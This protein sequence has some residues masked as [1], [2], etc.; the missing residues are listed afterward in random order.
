MR[1][2][3]PL[4]A[5][6]EAMPEPRWVMA[7]G[8]CAVSGGVAGGGYACGNGLDGVLPV[9]L[10]LPGCPPNPA[11][12]IEALLMFLDRRPQ[13]VSRRPPWRMN[14]G[15]SPLSAWFAG[16]V[17]AL[18][19]RVL[20]M[21]R[22]LLV[23]GGL[24]GRCRGRSALPGGAEAV[25]LPTRLAGEAVVPAAAGGAWLLGFGLARRPRLLAG[26]AGAPGER[27]VALRRRR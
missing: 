24:A 2:A 9:D 13:R 8:T 1:C 20:R 6:Y 4:R 16:G 22:L 12:M 17:L 15:R 5:A 25:A 11:A 27:R 7:T 26:E 18:G 21:A 23:L 19:G 10:Y 3:A 14:S